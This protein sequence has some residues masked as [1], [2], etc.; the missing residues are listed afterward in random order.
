VVSATGVRETKQKTREKQM[1]DI[2]ISRMMQNISVT[3]AE[4]TR[5]ILRLQ[6]ENEK[7]KDLLGFTMIKSGDVN[8]EQSA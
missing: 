3:L 5:E 6:A 8:A 7:L 1:N 4:A 2:Y